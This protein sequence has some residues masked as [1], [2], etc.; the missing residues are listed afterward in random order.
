VT[1]RQTKAGERLIVHLF[2]DINTTSGHG[3]PAEEV[4][5]REEV[6]PISDIRVTFNGYG[7]DQV[8]LQPGETALEMR[9]TEDKVEVTVPRLMVHA[10]VV[11]EL[12]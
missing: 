2:N 1:V 9:K 11:A 4:P 12:K 3:H 8:H 7:I 5:L 6:I 10:M